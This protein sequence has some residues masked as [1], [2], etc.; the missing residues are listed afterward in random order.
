MAGGVGLAGTPESESRLLLARPF[1]VPVSTI[2]RRWPPGGWRDCHVVV[3]VSGGADSVALVRALT[4][5]RGQE[6][7]PGKLI[8]AHF[9]HQLR[10]PAAD[11]DEAW[12]RGLA[13]RLG[14]QAVVGRAR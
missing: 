9:N 5:I 10:G 2:L 14:L 4:A 8:I 12:V 1:M 11:Q 13:S 6:S 7:G 3:A